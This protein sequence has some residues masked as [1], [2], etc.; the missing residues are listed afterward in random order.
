MRKAMLKRLLW[1]ALLALALCPGALPGE[2]DGNVFRSKSGG[3]CISRPDGKWEF[4]ERGKVSRGDYIL[5]LYPRTLQSTVQVNIRVKLASAAPGSPESLRDKAL[6]GTENQPQYSNRAKRTLK[7]AG[8]KAPGLSI[9]SKTSG[10]TYRLQQF[11][12][13]EKGLLFTLAYHAPL[14]E[15]D[16]LLPRFVSILKT[17]KFVEISAAPGEKGSL[18]RLAARCGT[19]IEWVTEWE[20][21]AARARR[22]KRLILVLVRSLSG[23]QITNPFM[24]GPFMD[25]DILGL[26]RT[27]FVMLRFRKGMGAPF[28]SHDVYGLSPGTFGTTLLVATPRGRIVGDTFSYEESSVHD[29][30]VGT[31]AAHRDLCRVSPPSGLRGPKRARWAIS[32]GEYDTA[33]GLLASPASAQEH[34]LRARLFRRLRK[35]GDALREIEKARGYADPELADDLAL[36]DALVRMR[37]GDRKAAY[38]GLASFRVR[39]PRSPRLPEALFW[40]GACAI[41]RSGV[42]SAKALWEE[43]IAGHPENRWS[44]KAAASLSSTGFSLGLGERTGWPPEEILKTLEL[45]PLEKLGA[46]RV[47]QAEQDALRYLLSKQRPDG[48]WVCPSEVT[49]ASHKLPMDFTVAITAICAMSL[50]P[51]RDDARILDAVH[52]ALGYLVQA[53]EIQ[54]AVGD[55]VYFMDYT[56]WRNAYV[57]ACLAACIEKGVV[58]KEKFEP[59]MKE[60]IAELGTKQKSGGGWSYY[61]T[62]DLERGTAANQSISFSTAAVLLGLHGAREAGV[63]VP[64]SLWSKAVGCLERMKCADGTFEYMLFHGAGRQQKATAGPG[65]AGRGPLCALTLYR[66]GRGDLEGMRKALAY[67]ALHR[68][69]YAALKR[70]TLMHT[71]PHSQG[72]HY[73]MFDYAYA[74]VALA[75]LPPKQR[76]KFR[77]M[78]LDQ[79]L[80]SRGADGSY[81]DNP[82][83]G[84]HVGTAFALMAFQHLGVKK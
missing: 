70:K 15:F 67:F 32:C 80:D 84:P 3:F 9:D 61:V 35:G 49:R 12:L 8:R 45:P 30:L 4:L 71:G 34:L 11:Y 7:L 66:W 1:F 18:Q 48:S 59:T 64:E 77:G 21:A 43:L 41:I 40:L 65:S 31:L 39:Y 68:S 53:R 62:T 19:E 69:S 57:L 17:F 56:V 6:K 58:K 44:W 46:D 72:S 16:A 25:P 29:L 42:K 2:E 13:A 82:I 51:Y 50:L 73:L 83:A 37:M 23:F 52:L 75:Q 54:K 38:S 55:K 20:E 22:G 14:R 26:I 63:P 10:G 27:R 76:G 28:E 36:E 24:S 60:L 79:I 74:A 81:V 78:L 5:A 33:R 47:R